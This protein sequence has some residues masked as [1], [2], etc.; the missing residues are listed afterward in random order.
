MIQLDEDNCLE[1]VQLSSK[2][3]WIER[4]EW[5]V[6]GSLK[7][8]KV[9]PSNAVYLYVQQLCMYAVQ[10]ETVVRRASSEIFNRVLVSS[11]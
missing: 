4:K 5:S 7:H 10:S 11:C 1:D 8:E 6:M 3:Q 9:Y 2:L